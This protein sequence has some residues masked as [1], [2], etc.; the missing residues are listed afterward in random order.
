VVKRRYI[1]AEELFH[2]VMDVVGDRGEA[3][4]DSGLDEKDRGR[5]PGVPRRVG[6]GY[7][8]PT[9]NGVIGVVLRLAGLRG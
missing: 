8:M 6:G 9:A 2:S 4:G 1:M 5:Y 7:I 3:R